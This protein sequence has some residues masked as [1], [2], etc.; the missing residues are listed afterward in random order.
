[1]SKFFSDDRF[2]SS[3]A[4]KMSIGEMIN[5]IDEGDLQV[6]DYQTNARLF[7]FFIKMYASIWSCY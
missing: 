3:E 2:P 4:T 7:R 1:M 5:R 6:P